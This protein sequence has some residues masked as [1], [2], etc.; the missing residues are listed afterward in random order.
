MGLAAQ[1]AAELNPFLQKEGFRKRGNFFFK[2]R[3]DLAFCIY[4]EQPTGLVHSGFCV[5]PLYLPAECRYLTYG[6]R[7]E[8]FSPCPV[9]PLP[10]DGDAVQWAERFRFALAEF[11]FPF[12]DSISNPQD[13]ER[14]LNGKNKKIRTYFFCSDL[15]LY[16]LRLYTKCYLGQW[17]ELSALLAK[18]EAVLKKSPHI[19]GQ[20]ADQ[21]RQEC[22]S[23]AQ[24]A[25]NPTDATVALESV[26][27]ETKATLFHL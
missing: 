9:G 23:L 16:R 21:F 26:I 24:N 22:A 10:V 2:I 19:Q 20:M 7:L 18:S 17:N 27:S 12:F 25:A 6:T 15:D 1:M 8:A 4:L 3:N 13:L 11:I 14:F 5:M